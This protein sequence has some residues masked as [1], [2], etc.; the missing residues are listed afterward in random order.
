MEDGEAQVL[1]AS[2]PEA[3]REESV[4]SGDKWSWPLMGVQDDHGLGLLG[5]EA[6]GWVCREGGQECGEQQRGR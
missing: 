6:G 2:G 3:N 4:D 1:E 5:L